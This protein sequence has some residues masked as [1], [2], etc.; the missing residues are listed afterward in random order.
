M[1]QQWLDQLKALIETMPL[2]AG[3][4]TCNLVDCRLILPADLRGDERAS[5]GVGI[6]PPPEPELSFGDYHPWRYAW[7]LENIRPLP[8]P[9]P[10]K[11]RIGLWDWDEV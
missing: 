7:I 2:G 9:V 4:C 3:L 1:N 5:N 6:T 10:V 11:G 8:F